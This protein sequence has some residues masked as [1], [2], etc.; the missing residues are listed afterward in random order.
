MNNLNPMRRRDKQK[1]EYFR[2]VSHTDSIKRKLAAHCIQ[3]GSGI[4][5]LSDGLRMRKASHWSRDSNAIL[6]GA[7]L[8]HAGTIHGDFQTSGLSNPRKCKGRGVNHTL[9]V[10]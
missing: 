3:N 5:V 10:S 9:H 1:P 6:C 4:D 2:V 8:I 7:C